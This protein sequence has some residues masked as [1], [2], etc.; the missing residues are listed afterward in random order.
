MFEFAID[1]ELTRLVNQINK[2]WELNNQLV[3]HSRKRCFRRI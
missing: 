3:S 1:L 2:A